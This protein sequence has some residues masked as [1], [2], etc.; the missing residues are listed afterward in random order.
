MKRRHNRINKYTLTEDD[1]LIERLKRSN[2]SPLE[3]MAEAFGNMNKAIDDFTKNV[4]SS[5]NSL[6]EPAY[7]LQDLINKMD[8]KEWYFYG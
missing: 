5:L 3:K 1:Y 7:T 6:K 4:E 8:E 2:K